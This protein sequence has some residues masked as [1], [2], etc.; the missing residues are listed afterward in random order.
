MSLHI[1]IGM[2]WGKTREASLNSSSCEQGTLGGR[3]TEESTRF[4][5]W[6]LLCWRRSKLCWKRRSM[7]QAQD[8]VLSPQDLSCSILSSQKIGSLSNSLPCSQHL[9]QCLVHSR[10]S[11]N[12]CKAN[13]WING[14]SRRPIGKDR[15]ICDKSLLHIQLFSNMT[16]LPHANGGERPSVFRW[17]SISL[18]PLWKSHR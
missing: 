1:S 10:W 12:V 17:V 13:K 16:L 14:T 8:L 2:S 18:A 3:E 7:A 5:E 11:I 6:G 4:L 15:V 9:V